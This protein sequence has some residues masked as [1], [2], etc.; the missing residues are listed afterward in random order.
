MTLKET[1][2]ALAAWEDAWN[3][4][5]TTPAYWKYHEANY[6]E[7]TAR[8]ALARAR[9]EREAAWDDV[10]ETPEYAEYERLY[11]RVDEVWAAYNKEKE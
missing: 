3:T 8:H 2:A 6:A 10:R 4:V 11:E 9:E 7:Y 1:K 5:K